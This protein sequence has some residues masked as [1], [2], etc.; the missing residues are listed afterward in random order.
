MKINYNHYTSNTNN[1]YISINRANSKNK[2]EPIKRPSTAPQKEKNEK[3]PNHS[4]KEL[5]KKG[6]KTNFISIRET[7]NYIK[8]VS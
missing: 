3:S 1:N 8:K 5:I 7:G 4:L 6:K 2:N